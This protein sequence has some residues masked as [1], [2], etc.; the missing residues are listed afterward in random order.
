MR[1]MEVVLDD[2]AIL[3]VVNDAAFSRA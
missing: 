2:G 3:N 1:R